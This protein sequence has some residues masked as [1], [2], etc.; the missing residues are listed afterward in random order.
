[1]FEGV[2]IK[3]T[4]L[5]EEFLDRLTIEKAEIWKTNNEIRYWTVFWFHS[6]ERNLPGHLSRVMREGWFGDM[7]EGDTKYVVFRNEV[8]SYTIGNAAEKEAVMA[9]CR[10]RGIP[11][12][13]MRWS[14]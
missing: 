7:K 3:E 14:E 5:D 11:D 10:E 2:L 8:L 1:M 9:R 4:I 12:E 6:E 13:Q